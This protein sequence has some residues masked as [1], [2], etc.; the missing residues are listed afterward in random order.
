[1]LK[2]IIKRD[3]STE[4]FDPS[5]LNRWADWAGKEL[6]DKVDWSTVV[7]HTVSNVPETFSSQDLQLRLI[8]TCLDMD[9]WSY[10]LMAGRLYA[11][12]LH[13]KILGESFP[14]V[15]DVQTK[16]INEGIMKHMGYTVDDYFLIN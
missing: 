12:Y 4:E 15:K 14:T 9:T 10:N 2:T 3:G 7:M 8:K 13:K 16:L 1:M 5:K 11:A 6:G